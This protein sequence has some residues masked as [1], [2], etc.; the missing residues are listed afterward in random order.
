MVV[1]CQA[2]LRSNWPEVLEL[3]TQ[4]TRRLPIDLTFDRDWQL[5]GQLNQP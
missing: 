5:P 2:T 4:P 3:A 1:V